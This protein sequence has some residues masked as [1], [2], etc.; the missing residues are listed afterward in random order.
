MEFQ[1]NSLGDKTSPK[2]SD[3]QMIQ[4]AKAPPNI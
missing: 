2:K 4:G 1:K 3:C